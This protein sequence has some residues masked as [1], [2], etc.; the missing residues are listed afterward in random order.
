MNFWLNFQQVQNVNLLVEV[1]PNATPKRTYFMII[2]RSV[3]LLLPML[4][5]HGQREDR[6]EQ[7]VSGLL[8][9]LLLCGRVAQKVSR[10][11]WHK[12]L[13]NVPIFPFRLRYFQKNLTL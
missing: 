6:E 12:S 1:L 11:T 2:I 10:T 3:R 4:Y 9:P 13:L 8:V 7:S 5:A